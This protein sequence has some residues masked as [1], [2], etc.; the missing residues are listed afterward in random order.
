[1]A[2][3]D[4]IRCSVLAML[5]IAV[6][7][8]CAAGPRTQLSVNSGNTSAVLEY[9]QVFWRPANQVTEG[10]EVVG[11]GFVGFYNDVLSRGYDPRWPTSGRVVIRMHGESRPNGEFAITLLG[12]SMTLGPGDDEM[13]TGAAQ[14]VQIARDSE[15]AVRIT[16]PP[17]PVQSRNRAGEALSLS[18]T[19]IARRTSENEF[20]R[21]LRQFNTER[22]Y[23]DLPHALPP[24]GR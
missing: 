16:L 20:E 3:P 24:G 5:M 12:P 17:T 23:R 8:G 22:S 21:Q 15:D 2:T 1:M 19:I 6:L 13:I 7:T 9:R 11:Y 10:V 14:G 18:G 4:S